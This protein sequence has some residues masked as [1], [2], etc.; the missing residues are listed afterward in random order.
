MQ[1]AMTYAAAATCLM[2]AACGKPSSVASS[3]APAEAMRTAAVLSGDAKGAA[4]N[5]PQCKA[6]TSAEAGKYIGE[7]VSGPNNA[8]MGSG[9]QWLA[10]DGS[11]DVMVQV[12]PAQYHTQPSAAPGY[13]EV[14][15]VGE[16]GF[17]APE[18]GG[19]QAG[20]IA[21]ANAVEV[22]VKGAT[23]SPESAVALLK[24]AILRQKD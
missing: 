21:G 14:A 10:R 1:R 3:G 22:S 8:A 12:V 17:V 24:E 13:K 4:A 15:G 23:A 19:W 2:V 16:K 9:C 6:F 7:P 5:N 20:A 11:G 18:M